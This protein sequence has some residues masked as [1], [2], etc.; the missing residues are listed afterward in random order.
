MYIT[1]GFSKWTNPN[2]QPEKT[3][4]TIRNTIV[5]FITLLYPFEL[6][7]IFIKSIAI[8]ILDTFKIHTGIFTYNEKTYKAPTMLEL[9]NRIFS[10]FLFINF[11]TVYNIK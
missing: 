5:S 11:P 1:F 3:N 9:I 4:E 6:Y 8:I 10:I 7:A 2:A